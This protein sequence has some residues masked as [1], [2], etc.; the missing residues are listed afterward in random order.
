MTLL[1]LIAILSVTNTLPF[2]E[3]ALADEVIATIS[4]DKWEWPYVVEYNPSNNCIYVANDHSNNV[5]VIDSTTNEVIAVVK[6]GEGPWALEYN[7]SNNNIYVSN[8]DSDDV[9]VIDSTTNEVVKT[10]KVGSEP[11]EIEFNP[12]NSKMYVANA[13]SSTVSVIDSTTNEART[14]GEALGIPLEIEYNPHNDYMYVSSYYGGYVFVIDSTT[15]EVVK[16]IKVGNFPT[17]V[18]YNPYN[19]DI[20]VVNSGKD[21][22]SADVHEIDDVSVIDST[23]NEVVKTIKVGEVPQAEGALE[24]NPNNNNIYVVNQASDDISVIDS[25]TNEVV[26]TIEGFNFVPNFP[27][28]IEYNPQNDNLYVAETKTV[29]VINSS[30][31]QIKETLNVGINPTSIEYNPSNDH[32]YVANRQTGEISVIGTTT[33]TSLKPIADAGPNQTV[34]SKD[35][36][37]LDGSNSS[38]PNGSPLT[39]SWNQTSGPQVTLSDPTV[40]NPTFTAPEVNDQTGLTFQLTVTNEKGI[41]SEPDDVVIIIDPISQPPPEEPRTIG[42]LL[43]GI[44]QNPLD[45]ANSIHSANQI[46][47]ILSDDDQNND[48]LVCDLIDT[49]NEQ[50]SNIRQILNC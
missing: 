40:S 13:D 36:V 11:R 47:D 30:S 37:Q 14:I 6:V 39:Y 49:E 43:K 1:A 41:A 33:P 10:I 34:D 44:I 7:P 25:T 4:S 38:D 16:G 24:F 21:G 12:H 2:L 23:T 5:T 27:G 45:V 48:H 50:T 32:M 28:S 29:S 15:N 8:R 26:K 18:M 31:N 19:N 17:A 35:A 22:N 9:S 42:D 20:Y 3:R 46:R